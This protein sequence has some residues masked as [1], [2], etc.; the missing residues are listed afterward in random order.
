[1]YKYLNPNPQNKLIGDCV[2]RAIA[3]SLNK[4]WEDVYIE[5]CIQGL[6]MHDM[7]SSNRVWSDYLHE[8]GY[9]DTLVVPLSVRNFSDNNF[10]NY[11]LGTGTHAVASIGGDYYDTWDSGDELV[12][13][14]FECIL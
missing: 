11:I 9:K 4:P 5:L 12:E 10:G 7:P 3:I 2:V 13:R 8:I 14:V 1:M 6:Y